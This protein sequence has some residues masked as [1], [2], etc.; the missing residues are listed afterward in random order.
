MLKV[1]VTGMRMRVRARYRVTGSVLDDSVT[2]VL[3]K[4]R[5]RRELNPRPLD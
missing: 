5:A 1:T 3:E 2:E 4:W